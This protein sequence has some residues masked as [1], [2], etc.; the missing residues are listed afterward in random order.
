VKSVPVN[1]SGVSAIILKSGNVSQEFQNSVM[2]EFTKNNLKVFR[3]TLFTKLKSSENIISSLF[4]NI[5]SN[6]K[7]GKKF[8]IYQVSLSPQEFKEFETKVYQL[9]K[10]GYEFVNFREMMKR[11]NVSK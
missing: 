3:D 6:S 10:I 2:D 5:I 7:S 9:K 4:E 1:F 11:Q 8:L